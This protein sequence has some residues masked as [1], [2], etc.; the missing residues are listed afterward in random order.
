MA[1]VPRLN[2]VIRALEEG[3]TPVTTFVSPPS[4]EG[5]IALSTTAYDGLVFEYEHQPYDVK[6]LR[7]C[8]STC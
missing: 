4:V 3:Q 1:A 8:L 6:D 7:D 2:G 5:A